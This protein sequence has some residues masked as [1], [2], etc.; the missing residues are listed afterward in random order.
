MR[1]VSSDDLAVL[2]AE[3]RSPIGRPWLPAR[4]DGTLLPAEAAAIRR[5]GIAWARAEA[6]PAA[7]LSAIQAWVTDAIAWRHPA[8]ARLAPAA[9][10]A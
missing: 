8:V 1:A 7:A 5:G 4:R 9:W 3:R 2:S 6:E 10:E